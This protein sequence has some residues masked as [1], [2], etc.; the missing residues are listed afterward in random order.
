LERSLSTIDPV[1]V[2][3]L[4]CVEAVAR[5]RHFTR[6]ADELHIAQSALSHQVRRLEAE[7]GVALFERTSRR[8]TPTEAGLAV[9]ARAR[10]VLAELDEAR[11]EV[12][13]LRGA[14]RGRLWI[15]PLLRA[16]DI[17]VPGLIARFGAQHTGIEVRL[18]EG[19]AED[20]FRHLAA[21][22]LD[23][24]FCLLTGKLGD[25]FDGERLGEDEV[26]VAFGAGAAP[27][28]PRVSV[29]ELR[30]RTL[31]GPRRGAAVTRVF[32]DLFAAAGAPLHLALES[33]DPILLRSLAARGF[34]AA[35][36][37]RSL[38][39]VEGPAVEVRGLDPPVR[40]PVALVWRRD[41]RP[42]PAAQTFIDF[43]RSDAGRR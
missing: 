13:Q 7:L 37:P 26:V 24:A 5:L 16:G 30:E 38:T 1:D 22:E 3:Q 10:R 4:M 11:Q 15:G 33:G 19:L 27:P 2:R 32:D 42:S 36:L 9:A 17:D 31:V 6:A 40:L 25:R 29:A 21:D 43:V 18:R 41:R 14:L 34:G 20:M 23:V 28:G 35:L 12:D 39:A 8:V